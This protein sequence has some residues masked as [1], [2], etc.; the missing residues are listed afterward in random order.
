[1]KGK[2]HLIGM[3]FEQNQ[4]QRSA[5]IFPAAPIIQ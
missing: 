3:E 2:E 1:M 4:K 5:R